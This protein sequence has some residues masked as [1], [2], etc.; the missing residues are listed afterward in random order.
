[1]RR[2]LT[3]EQVGQA[4]HDACLAELDA[5]KPGNVHRFGDDPRMSVADFETSARVAAAPLAAAGASVGERIRASVEATIDAVGRNTNLGIVVLGAPLAAAAL[6]S[7]SGDLRERLAKV[8][9]GLSVADAREV[10]AAIRHAKPGG[11]GEAP[12]HDVGKEPEI[13]LLE[14]MEAAEGRDRI[15]WNYTHDFADVFDLG[16]PRLEQAMAHSDSLPLATTSVYLGFL[17]AIPDTLL[18]RKF[19]MAQALEVQ[20]EAKAVAARLGSH[21]DEQVGNRELMAFDR[22]LKSR[23]LNPGTSADLTVATLFAASL[24][25]SETGC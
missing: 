22:S 13:T 12:A 6:E 14:A 16:L 4:F 3:A 7:A 20:Q 1:M 17:A 9:A 23:G 21:A 18:T 24:Q 19:G 10:Y 5:L 8:L 11:L 2:P 25:A 15:A